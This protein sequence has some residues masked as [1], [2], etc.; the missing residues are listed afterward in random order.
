M[1][2]SQKIVTWI[3]TLKIRILFLIAL[4]FFPSN[5]IPSSRLEPVRYEIREVKK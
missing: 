2:F 4:I 5:P 3:Q 1:C